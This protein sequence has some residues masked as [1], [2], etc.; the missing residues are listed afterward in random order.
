M[1]L[2]VTANV[3]TAEDPQVLFAFTVMFPPVEVVV[4]FIELVLEDPVHP[5]GS[6]HV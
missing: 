4:A 2:D 6:V 1:E 3:C 5:A